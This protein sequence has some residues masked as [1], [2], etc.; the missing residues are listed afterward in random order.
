MISMI[1]RIRRRNTIFTNIR[2]DGLIPGST[3]LRITLEREKRS[4]LLLWFAAMFSQSSNERAWSECG[5]GW[6]D[7]NNSNNNYSLIV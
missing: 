2:T 3:A 7:N 5:R 6:L 1:V 4:D